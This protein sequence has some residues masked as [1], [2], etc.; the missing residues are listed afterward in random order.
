[1][2][3]YNGQTGNPETPNPLVGSVV[4]SDACSRKLGYL[5]YQPV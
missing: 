5:D 2:T 3:F 1:M 4:V